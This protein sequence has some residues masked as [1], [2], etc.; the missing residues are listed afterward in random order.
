[1]TTHVQPIVGPSLDR[2]L[3]ML[4][5]L[6]ALPLLALLVA[7]S[8]CASTSPNTPTPSRTSTTDTPTSKADCSP[9]AILQ[10]L[11]ASATMIKFDCA[12]AGNTDW[13]A[14]QVNPGTTVF[15]L[16]WNGT[17]WDAEDSDSVCGTASAGLPQ[18]LL[19]YCK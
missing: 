3:R 17:A 6:T 11:P 4:R 12:T 14:A 13:A 10:A 2:C 7:M 5:H 9:D 16:Q 19:A 1:M 8:A 15:F 18:K